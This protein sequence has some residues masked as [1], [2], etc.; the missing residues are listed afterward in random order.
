MIS[1][2][3]QWWWDGQHWNPTRRVRLS[4][5]IPIHR[6]LRL[7][8]SRDVEPQEI[9]A[10]FG[11][12]LTTAGF[13]LTLPAMG[14]GTIFS[15]AIA[16]RQAPLWPTIGQ[17]IVIFAVVLGFL[18]SWPLIGLLLGFGL[19]D[20]LRWVL[21]SLLLSGL[22]PGVSLGALT[23]ATSENR[24]EDFAT[25][26]LALAWLWAIPALGLVALRAMHT[27]R[28]LPRLAAFA[29]MFGSGWREKLPGLQTEWGEVAWRST[30]GYVIRVP[31]A[32]FWLPPEL[33]GV[34][35]PVKVMYDLRAGRVETV[36]VV[37]A[38]SPQAS[39]DSSA[40]FWSR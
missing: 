14:A 26:E 13:V 38:A 25:L 30:A 35:G 15:M 1:P 24:A 7:K 8:Y 6:R 18:G 37:D 40:P 28:P 19:R 4:P 29:G 31:G 21:L 32:D 12:L 23:L 33:M 22:V 20:G 16:T 9:R 2:D 27:G 17:G 11:A 39:V 3:G 5:E 36:Q 34:S 10:R